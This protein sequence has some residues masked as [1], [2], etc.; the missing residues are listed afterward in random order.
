MLLILKLS[1]LLYISEAFLEGP[2]RE[3]K[4]GGLLYGLR[5]LYVKDT[6]YSSNS[7]INTCASAADWAGCH[8]RG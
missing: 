4:I 7:V 2:N 3:K 1:A 6:M 8:P 5:G